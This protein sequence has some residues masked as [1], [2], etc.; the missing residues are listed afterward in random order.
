MLKN[1]KKFIFL[2]LLPNM[3]FADAISEDPCASFLAVIDRPTT[4]SSVCAV[5]SGQVVA[6]MGFQYK[7]HYPENGNSHNFPQPVVRFGLPAS[8]E[9][10][11]LP[12]DYITQ[13]VAGETQSG[14]AATAV[15]LK[16]QF[17]P[18]AKL[19]YAG[20]GILALPSGDSNFGSDGLGFALNGIASYDLTTAISLTLML[21]FSS[22]TTAAN[23]GGERYDSFNPDLVISWQPKDVLQLY[24]EFYGQTKTGPEEAEGY[25]TDAGIQY[26]LTEDIEVDVEYGQRLSGELNGFSHYVGFGGG[27]R[28]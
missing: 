11:I 2:L 26:L 18:L 27:V 10:L 13:H 12:S 17:A 3:G 20:K 9:L 28:F 14:Y 4:A 6:S 24:I 23:E 15:G 8:N 25:N 21:G 5:K 19:I 16:H 22:Q 7:E 1:Y